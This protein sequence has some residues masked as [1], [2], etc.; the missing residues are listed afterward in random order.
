MTIM[1][2]SPTGPFGIIRISTFDHRTVKDA[3]NVLKHFREKNA[4]RILIDFSGN[5]GGSFQV[6][7]SFSEL[8]VPKGEVMA[9]LHTKKSTKEFRSNSGAYPQKKIIIKVDKKTASSAEI[10]AGILQKQCKAVLIGAKS[11]GK[12]TVQELFP[13]SGNYSLVLTIG[14]VEVEGAN[15]CTGLTPDYILNEET[16]SNKL[17]KE[18]ELVFSLMRKQ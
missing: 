4:D 8:F 1:S 12:C 2:A 16:V 10:V 13:L 5:G 17:Q 9:L 3:V 7:M 15:I 14:K 18:L 6:A 11:A